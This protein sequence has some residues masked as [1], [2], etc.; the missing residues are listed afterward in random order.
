M[1]FVNLK[2]SILNI[3]PNY[4]E[5]AVDILGFQMRPW[6]LSKN[7]ATTIVVVDIHGVQR[8]WNHTKV[9]DIVL[10]SNPFICRF[11]RS[12]VFRLHC[13]SASTLW[14]DLLQLIVLPF[15]INV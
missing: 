14:F 4:V 9:C 6:L 8:T 2:I 3:I 15:K 11:L 7:Y 10:Y 12:H 13:R 1:Y 5:S